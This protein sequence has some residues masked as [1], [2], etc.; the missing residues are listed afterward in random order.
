MSE[1][2][3]EILNELDQAVVYEDILSWIEKNI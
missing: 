1:I 3:N 2:E